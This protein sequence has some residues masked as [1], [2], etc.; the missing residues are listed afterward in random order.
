L[1]G[2]F[3]RQKKQPITENWQQQKNKFQ[4]TANI[5]IRKH[6]RKCKCIQREQEE[7]TKLDFGCTKQFQNAWNLWACKLL[8]I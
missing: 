2:F 5:F 3:L 1:F 6:L 4:P 7:K 8:P